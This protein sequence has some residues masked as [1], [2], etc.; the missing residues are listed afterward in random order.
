MVI[1]KFKKKKEKEEK[2]NIVI[3]FTNICLKN[4]QMDEQLNMKYYIYVSNVLS[5]EKFLFYR[6]ER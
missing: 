2:Y 4:I 1:R 3:I 5:S 6:L